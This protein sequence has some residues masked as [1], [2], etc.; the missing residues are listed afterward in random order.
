M[1][2]R[3]DEQRT[4]EDL[5]NLSSRTGEPLAL[6]SSHYRFLGF[7]CGFP[8]TT[9]L[10]QCMLHS[11]DHVLGFNCTVLFT[12]FWPFW[13]SLGWFFCSWSFNRKH[14]MSE[15]LS[16]QMALP[17]LIR[18]RTRD[19]NICE[20]LMA[21][22]HKFNKLECAFAAIYSYVKQILFTATFSDISGTICFVLI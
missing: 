2:L 14:L 8:I 9:V 3:L 1:E 18:F 4:S 7:L 10:Q 12:S 5:W 16:N 13:S 15:A 17:L 6:S 21:C 22:W 20:L 11:L 19:S